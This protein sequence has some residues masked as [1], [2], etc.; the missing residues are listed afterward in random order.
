[1]R[2]DA[3]CIAAPNLFRPALTLDEL[4]DAKRRLN[5]DGVVVAPG[6]PPDYHLP[7]ANDALAEVTQDRS[8]L[9]RLVRVDPNQ[10]DHAVQEVRRAVTGLGC[11]GLFLHPGEEVFV[12]RD[13]VAVVQA[14]ADLG[15]PTVVAAGLYA[16]SEPLQ[17]LEIAAAVPDATVV[18]STG[19]QINISG[20]AMVD[21]WRALERHE[22]LHVM[23]NGEYRQDFIERLARDLDPHRVLMASFA[24][25]FDQGYEVARVANAVIE[26]AAR[27]LVEGGNAERLFGVAPAP[28]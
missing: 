25:Y 7:P 22:N 20:L 9:A 17:V 28:G 8:D 12:I 13:A 10:G 4:D 21:A 24:P 27:A 19:G 14:A 15:V 6:R 26:P 11:R 1:M 3:L 2:I 16:L 18:M 23:T 5:L